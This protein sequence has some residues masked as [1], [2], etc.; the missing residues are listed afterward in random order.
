VRVRLAP[1]FRLYALMIR[2]RITLRAALVQGSTIHEPEVTSV[3]RK[4]KHRLGL[5]QGLT[6]D[7]NR[8]YD[9]AF[10]LERDAASK[11][12]IPPSFEACMPKNSPPIEIA[13][14][15]PSFEGQMHATCKPS[16]RK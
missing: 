15:I 2:R 4:Q 6:A 13:L 16:S 8:P 11:I 14:P 7:A 3:S 5:D 10:Q 9:L 12:M 1:D